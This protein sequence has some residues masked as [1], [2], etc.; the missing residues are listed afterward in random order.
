MSKSK[1]ELDLFAEELL[2]RVS[3]NV[4]RIREEKGFSQLK[5]ALEIGLSGAAYIGR[6][7]LR[8]KGYRFN[9]VHLAKIAKVLDV[10]MEEFFK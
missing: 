6:A 5:L 8:T 3:K 2:D 10:N 7:E 9:I 4:A 1:E